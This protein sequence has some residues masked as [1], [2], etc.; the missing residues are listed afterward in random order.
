MSVVEL[1]KEN[2]D[3]EVTEASGHV[4]VDFWMPGCG[5]CR[6]LDSVLEELANA[7]PDVRF[8]RMNA[9][10]FPDVAWAF[11][12]TSAPTLVR[13]E[14]GVPTGQLVGL[15]SAS[16]IEGFATGADV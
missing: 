15:T 8:A 13:F 14:G 16:R 3:R 10:A 7:H 12:V 5:P 2:F 11:E 1:T 9:A 6:A 4:V